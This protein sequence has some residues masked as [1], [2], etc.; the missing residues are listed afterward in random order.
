MQYKSEY[1]KASVEIGSQVQVTIVLPL[2]I[3]LG[4]PNCS[5]QEME[6]LNDIVGVSMEVTTSCTIQKILMH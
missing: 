4:M 2:A 1:C 3:A 6:H 5:V